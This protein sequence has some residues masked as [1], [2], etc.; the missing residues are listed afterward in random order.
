MTGENISAPDRISPPSELPLDSHQDQ[1]SAQEAKMGLETFL[2][3]SDEFGRLPEMNV[4][5]GA[6][7]S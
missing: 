7:F 5:S 2:V 4:K 6:L 1:N 3:Y